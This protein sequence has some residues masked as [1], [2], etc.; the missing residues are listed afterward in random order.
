[1]F[2]TSTGNEVI[3]HDTPEAR[4][5]QFAA[6]LQCIAATI[7]KGQGHLLAVDVSEPRRIDEKQQAIE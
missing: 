7:T 6:L 5:S 2:R 3:E 4:E 1:M